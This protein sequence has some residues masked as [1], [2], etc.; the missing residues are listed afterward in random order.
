MKTL[1]STLFISSFLFLNTSISAQEV[2]DLFHK[3]QKDLLSEKLEKINSITRPHYTFSID[4]KTRLNIDF[5]KENN[6]FR[7]D[8]VYLETLDQKH[9]K[10]N[11]EEDSVVTCRCKKSD[12]MGRKFKKFKRGCIEKRIVKSGI[13]NPSFR[14]NFKIEEEHRETFMDLIK[15]LIVSA[16]TYYVD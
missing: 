13:I 10:I 3:K 1:L 9:I 6:I 8:Q 7:T 14:M 16:N 4:D 12:D 2:V 5:S 15:E 11:V